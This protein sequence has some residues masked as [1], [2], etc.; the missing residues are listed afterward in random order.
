MAQKN[1]LGTDDILAQDRAHVWHPMLQHRSLDDKSLMVIR[2]A[3]GTTVTDAEGRSYLDAYA[4]LWNVNVGYGRDEIAQAIHDQVKSLSYYSNLQVTAP[5]ARL[6]ADRGGFPQSTPSRAGRLSPLVG[7][8]P[9]NA[10]RGTA[11][12]APADCR[13][14]I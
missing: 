2:E 5:A 14:T 11:S 12:T 3:K 13:P 6:A 10:L 9:E 4:G 1:E 7:A 8:A